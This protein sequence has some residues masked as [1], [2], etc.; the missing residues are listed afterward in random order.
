MFPK[1]VIQLFKFN[2]LGL[3]ITGKT[4]FEC[5][6]GGEGKLDDCIITPMIE[7]V[8]F[9]LLDL[10]MKPERVQLPVKAIA[11]KYNAFRKFIFEEVNSYIKLY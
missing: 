6:E 9:N 5:Y 4:A 3:P 1:K 8:G 10:F 2:V 11:K 7:L